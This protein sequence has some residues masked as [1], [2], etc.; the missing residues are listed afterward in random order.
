MG[1]GAVNSAPLHPALLDYACLDAAVRP[2]LGLPPHHI[3]PDEF[4]LAIAVGLLF[5]R[6]V[7][8][9]SAAHVNSTEPWLHALAF[10]DAVLPS[11]F[12]A[13][14]SSGE[15]CCS[16]SI[17]AEAAV[18]LNAADLDGKLGAPSLRAPLC[19]GPRDPT[20]ITVE[21]ASPKFDIIEEPVIVRRRQRPD[22]GQLSTSRKP[23]T[24]S[25]TP[26][27]RAPDAGPSNAAPLSPVLDKLRPH[28]R[29]V[30][31]APDVPLE[32]ITPK[33]VRQR[34]VACGIPGLTA[35]WAYENRAR[36]KPIIQ[37]EHRAVKNEKKRAKHVD[38]ASPLSHDPAP[39]PLQRRFAPVSAESEEQKRARRTA[40]FAPN[41]SASTSTFNLSL[42]TPSGNDSPCSIRAAADRIRCGNDATG[43]GVHAPTKRLPQASGSAAVFQ[44]V[45]DAH[46]QAAG[47]LRVGHT[48]HSVLTSH[49]PRPAS[50]NPRP[51]PVAHSAASTSVPDSAGKKR[52]RSAM[53]DS[54]EDEFAA[55][56]MRKRKVSASLV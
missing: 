4:A 13:P 39:M 28:I 36:L 42:H 53:T 55:S 34:L 17:A 52:P 11:S 29:A 19:D 43:Q 47:D 8:A 16:T 41:S 33:Q 22:P 6:F 46:R 35:E 51:S 5:Q 38:A 31:S 20:L 3:P 15:D 48:Q 23:P 1:T 18:E 7:N 49:I 45:A 10:A 32:T 12:Q 54:D 24:E 44:S 40:A 56:F 37:E 30:L 14:L 21:P 50:K 26:A 25:T 9:C 2:A 27:L